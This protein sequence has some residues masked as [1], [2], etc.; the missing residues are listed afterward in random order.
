MKR[1]ACVL[2]LL[3]LLVAAEGARGNDVE[4]LP[5]KKDRW[6]LVIGVDRYDDPRLWSLPGAANDARALRDA[7]IS[8]AGFPPDQVILI[9]RGGP[10]VEP[11]T[12]SNILNTVRKLMSKVP[13]KGLLLLAFSGH[14]V[15]RNGRA[16]LLPSDA[17]LGDD[18]ELDGSAVS[19]QWIQGQIRKT[20][21]S[22]VLLLLDACKNDPGGRAGV[23]NVLS[24]AYT[25]AF[26]FDTRDD[27]VVAFATFF[28]TS[29]NEVAYE[30]AERQQGYFMEAIVEGLRGAAAND[31]GEVTLGRLVA[32]VQRTVAKRVEDLGAGKRQHPL[33]SIVGYRADALV[34]VPGAE[35]PR[36][37][38]VATG[39]DAV[40]AEALELEME[41]RLA[42]Y[43]GSDERADADIA[44]LLG[45]PDLSTTTLSPALSKA[46]FHILVLVRVEN[47]TEDADSI[48]H[49][50]IRLHAYLLPANRTIG[51][52]WTERI[53]YAEL[54]LKE[55][56]R[57][58]FVGA[59]ADLRRSIEAAKVQL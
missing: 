34:L 7:L 26:Q 37:A 55:K 5:A 31:F 30:S 18:D 4:S 58:A 16:Y 32:Y 19:L 33:A 39:S 49:A 35:Q 36:I 41:R 14:G 43:G 57:Q 54:S 47:V 27:E 10:P 11:P 52:G 29:S 1:S 56:A 50:T 48:K 51:T 28:A 53:E 17:K 59:T 46:G 44:S 9:A 40:L 38:V 2:L 13:R 45:K 15:D 24:D 21:V 3:G 23:P 20:P 12:Q 42:A 6:A 8:K 22:Q 25:G